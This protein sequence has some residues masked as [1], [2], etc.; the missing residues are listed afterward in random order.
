MDLAKI[1]SWLRLSK[2]ELSPRKALDLIERFG[3]PEAI[4][5]AGE[6]ELRSI[7]GLTGRSIE[8]LLTPEPKDLDKDLA[9][10]DNHNISLIT[11]TDEN[12]PVNLRQIYDPP[13]VLYVQ[14][15]LREAD[16][17]SVG[18]VGSRKA[19]IYGRSV[20]E[21]IARDLS[22]R[23]LC[24]ISGGARGI[25]A[26]AHKGT[27]A[28]GGRTIAVLGCG[29]DIP[30]PREH[31][32]LFHK[33]SQSG[34][35]VSEFPPGTPPEGWR[36]PT[37]NRIISGLSLGVLVIQA[38]VDSGALI[39]AGFAGDHGKPVFALPGNVDDILNEGSHALIR[40][41]AV[42]IE[43]ADHILQEL[44]II[45]HEEDQQKSQ[46]SLVFDSLPDEERK[47]VELLSLQPKH[48]DQIIEESGFPAPKVTGALTLLEMKGVIKRVPG[49]AYVRAL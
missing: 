21:K 9:A 39:T 47:L 30:Y 43:S 17:F 34:A 7:E 3:C 10:L 25:D 26:A 45:P 4:F 27:L 20:A 36:F 32:E 13:V 29:I 46:L 8:K 14:G 11:I 6:V 15:E 28:A 23:G 48:V 24:I 12:Y 42:L 5:A 38:P 19:S 44:G 41:G 1:R 33:V 31:K 16:R 35:V 40:D 18:I 2:L 37:R 22:N 49:N